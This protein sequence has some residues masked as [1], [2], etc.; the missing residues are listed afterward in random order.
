MHTN[1]CMLSMLHGCSLS[2]TCQVA[3]TELPDSFVPKKNSRVRISENV[4][5]RE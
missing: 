5:I 1:V 3:I 2:V 4:H